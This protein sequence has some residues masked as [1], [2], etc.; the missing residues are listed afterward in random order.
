MEEACES[1]TFASSPSLY[2]IKGYKRDPLGGDPRVWI[3]WYW[4]T[5]GLERERERKNNQLFGYSII[6]AKGEW[7][8]SY[9]GGG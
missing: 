9:V 7:G 1:C 3:D 4:I 5:L 8:N 6:E 2:L